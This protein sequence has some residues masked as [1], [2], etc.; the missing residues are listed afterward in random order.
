MVFRRIFTQN[1]ANTQRLWSLTKPK[2][3]KNSTHLKV[4]TSGFYAIKGESVVNFKEHSRKENV[5]EF[6]H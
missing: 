6:L 2:V 4:N 5:I 3:K 1:T